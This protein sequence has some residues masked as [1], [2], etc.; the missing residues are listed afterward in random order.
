MNSRLIVFGDSFVAPPTVSQERHKCWWELLA[1][2]LNS[3]DIIN[4]GAQ[5]TS[6]EYSIVKL[7][8]Y[9]ISDGYKTTDVILFS[10]SDP[11]RFPLV[12]DQYSHYLNKASRLVP[13]KYKKTLPPDLIGT[14][15]NFI[16]LHD[17]TRTEN[18]MKVL[19]T[20]I[21]STLDIIPN[22]TIVTSLHGVDIDTS[23]YINCYIF[24]QSLIQLSMEEFFDLRYTPMPEVISG[25]N[26]IFK[27]N[28]GVDTRVN[29]FNSQSHTK[30]FNMILQLI[31]G[32]E[33]DR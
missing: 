26:Q 10:I 30:L 24:K 19:Q 22:K 5:G 23:V 11:E 20:M 12:S 32:V 25:F 31:T 13:H 33:N 2:N 4:H 21:I 18:S 28:N 3:S 14:L 15:G 9:L 27:N 8:D 6:V 17:L 1:E 16:E 29:H 7:F